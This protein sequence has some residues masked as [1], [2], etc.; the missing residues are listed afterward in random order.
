MGHPV[1]QFSRRDFIHAG[2][3]VAAASLVPSIADRAHAGL[4]L[5]GSVAV[6]S[7]FNGGKSQGQ[8]GNVAES[9]DYPFLNYFQSNSGWRGSDSFNVDQ[10]IDPSWLSADGWPNGPVINANSSSGIGVGVG[11]S[12]PPQSSYTGGSGGNGNLVLTWTVTGAGPTDT[13]RWF[14]GLQSTTPAPGFT[15]ANLISTGNGTFVYKFTPSYNTGNSFNFNL[16]TAG[17]AHVTSAALVFD[18]T[19][20]TAYLAGKIFGAQFLARMAQLKYGVFRFMD[21]LGTGVSNTTLWSTRK[22]QSYVT[23]AD[24]EYRAN[25]SAG[26]TSSNVGNDYAIATMPGT[27]V[28]P[29]FTAGSAPVDKQTMHIRFNADSSFIY[30]SQTGSVSGNGGG[31]NLVVGPSISPLT[32]TWPSNPLSNGD[33]VCITNN[34][35]GGNPPSG[36]CPSAVY[37]VVGVSGNSFNVALTP[38]G[39]AIAS[40]DTGQGNTCVTRLSTLKIDGVNKIPILGPIALPVNSSIALPAATI[41][42]GTHQIWGTVTYDTSLNCWM[43]SGATN[44]N[45]NFCAGLQNFVPPEVCL[46]L[47]KELGMHPHWSLPGPALDTAT[48]YA[49]SLA[50]LC[51]SDATSKANGAWMIPHFEPGNEIWN[52]LSDITNFATGK[53]FSYWGTTGNFNEWYGKALSIMGQGVASIYGAGNLGITYEVMC[54]VQTANGLSPSGSGANPRL[55]T[56]QWTT[57]NQPSQSGYTISVASG[58]TSGV[59]TSTYVSPTMRGTLEEYFNAWQYYFVNGANPANPSAMQNLNN[60]VDTLSGASGQYNNQYNKDRYI[61]WKTWA[62]GFGVNKMFAYEGGYSPD[63]ITSGGDWN[64]PITAATNASQCVLTLAT[65]NGGDP[66][67]STNGEAGNPAIVGMCLGVN[68]IFTGMTQLNTINNNSNGLITFTDSVSSIPLTNNFVANQGIVFPSS[69]FGIPTP[70]PNNVN[71]NQTYFILSAGLSSTHFQISTTK[72]GSPLVP[73]VTGGGTVTTFSGWANGWVVTNVSG[74]SV[75]IDCDS[76]SFGTFTTSGNFASVD[77]LASLRLVNSFRVQ[78]LEFAS[79]LPAL[80]LANYNNFTAAG[81]AFPSQYQN[82]NSGSIWATMIPD[83]Y[84]STPNQQ[85]NMIAAYN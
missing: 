51:K 53:A 74:S 45:S 15:T 73:S 77:Y 48:D 69:A 37:Y 30:N 29:G 35:N 21:W 9:T 66:G 20:Y 79:D 46:E 57:Q 80:L 12:I 16:V 34:S 24:D 36:I 72:G 31:S 83:V 71:P 67:N 75:T 61:G 50:T 55:T 18:G 25:L 49:T 65:T 4:L 11:V 56:N 70:L 85:F 41:S 33:P 39:S 8:S 62:S 22:T 23:W 10:A 59:L 47:C 82:A 63:L 81:G 58:W 42:G 68:N 6:A 43:L 5:K 64:S 13:S 32:F 60:Y 40:G 76:T 38:G 54:G 28:W 1:K 27:Y 17:T 44:N 3:T 19:D 52:G 26:V 78:T 7:G 84:T 2:C 14:I